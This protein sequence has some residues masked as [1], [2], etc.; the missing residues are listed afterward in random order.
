[1]ARRSHYPPITHALRNAREYRAAVREI[2]R[3]LDGR[4]PKGSSA[5]DRLDLLSVL[6]QAWESEHLAN[7]DDPT[8]Q[9]AVDFMLEQRS[10][11][12]AD[13][14]PML[15]G[16]SRVSE[17]FSGKRRL[18]VPQIVAVRDALGIPADLLITSGKTTRGRSSRI[19]SVA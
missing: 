18:S 11:T 2:D 10:M 15:G 19:R 3:L 8:P 14:A 13:L 12:R 17:F 16:R 4:H 9:E 6:V 7:L 1:M 5:D